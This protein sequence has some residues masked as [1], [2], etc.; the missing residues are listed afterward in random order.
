MSFAAR[1]P[2]W[3]VLAAFLAGC[4]L[5]A[6][7]PAATPGAAPGA[8]AALQVPGFAELTSPQP[9]EVVTGLV[10]LRGTADHP[11]F[12]RFEVQFAYADDETDTWFS[13]GEPVDTPVID[14]R[15]ALWDTAGI[16]DGDYT[17]RLLVWLQDGRSLEAQ[18]PGVRVRNYTVVPTAAPAEAGGALPAATAPGPTAGVEAT[19]TV[20]ATPVP[21][22][23][24]PPSPFWAGAAASLFLLAGVAAYSLAG[25]PARAYL[26]HLRMRQL[27]RRIDRSR[28]RGGRR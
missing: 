23:S 7:A 9:G 28:T 19:T 14:G 6:A 12:N 15:L 2:S 22:P 1:R 13:I 18:V 10:T 25:P 21:P 4:A 27:H 5:L 16:T 24:A 3:A 26:A 20:Q 17:L 8:A 11:A